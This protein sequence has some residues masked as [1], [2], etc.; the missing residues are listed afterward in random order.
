MRLQSLVE[1]LSR[2]GPLALMAPLLVL[3]ADV[4]INAN[5]LTD[6]LARAIAYCQSPKGQA[7]YAALQG[8][9]LCPPSTQTTIVVTPSESGDQLSVVSSMTGAD[10]VLVAET[11][12]LFLPMQPPMP[13]PVA[14]ATTP[15]MNTNVLNNVMNARIAMD[16]ARAADLNTQPLYTVVRKDPRS[17][18][19]ALAGLRAFLNSVQKS[20]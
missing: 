6:R 10:D 7:F 14:V 2:A 19:P 3:G 12:P 17:N 9:P 20:I 11:T 5:E 8:R 18:A 13:P 4:D 1:Y 16:L 15:T